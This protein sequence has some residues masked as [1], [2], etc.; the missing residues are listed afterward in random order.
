VGAAAQP[1]GLG[2]AR[3]PHLDVNFAM[4]AG[5]LVDH[6]VAQPIDLTQ[7]NAASP[8]GFARADHDPPR[9]RIETHHIKGRTCGNA[10]SAPLA[11]G[12]MNDAVMVSEHAAVQVD[13]VAG[14]G[15]AGTQP[16]DHVGIA[17]AWHETNILTVLLIGD[18]ETKTPG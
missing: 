5:R 1:S 15:G 3:R 8:Q 17:T 7:T 16:L 12:E 9:G 18:G 4:T 11:D 2:R 6:A 13:D 14:S 10:Q